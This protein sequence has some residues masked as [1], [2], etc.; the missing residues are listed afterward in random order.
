MRRLTPARDRE[1]RHARNGRIAWRPTWNDSDGRY[2]YPWCRLCGRSPV[3]Q[4]DWL[5][6]AGYVEGTTGPT[7]P[8]DVLIVPA[9][10]GPYLERYPR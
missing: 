1:L 6:E 4:I 2:W 9:M 10:A 8:L 5:V 7:A 3:K